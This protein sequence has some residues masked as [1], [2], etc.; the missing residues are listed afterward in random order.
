MLNL[1][2]AS[3]LALDAKEILKLRHYLRIQLEKLRV[4]KIK[5]SLFPRAEL[6]S[7][8]ASYKFHFWHPQEW[9]P[10]KGPNPFDSEAF[11][12]FVVGSWDD[13]ILAE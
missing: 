7:F 8:L 13:E 3:F 12:A 5:S 2:Y 6:H 10:S 11:R 4:L 1:K 9:D